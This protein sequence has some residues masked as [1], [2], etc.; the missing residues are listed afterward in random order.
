MAA[1]FDGLPVWS[2]ACPDW[3]RRI[4]AR[5]SLVPCPPLFPAEAE[6]A[7]EVF[8]TL[9][10][11]DAPN[12]P[13]MAEI[14][15]PW[16]LDFVASI[17]G[18]YDAETGRRL[19]QEFF[20][21]ISKKNGKSTTA[22]GIMI[23]AL[24]RNWRESAEFIIL[25]PTIEIAKN[26]FEPARDMVRKHP[27]LADMLL[28]QEHTRTITHRLTNATLKV[29]AADNDTVGGKKGVGVLVDEVWLFGKRAGADAM[30]REALGGLASRPEGFV[31]WLSTQSDEPPRG[32]FRTK[33]QY[34]RGVRDGR[35]DDNRFLPVLYEFPAALLKAEKHKDP[36]HFYITNPN[37]GSSVDVPFLEREHAKALVDGE[38]ALRVFLSKHLNVEIGMALRSDRWAGADYWERPANVDRTLTLDALI[39]RSEVIVL[40]AD[41]GGADDLFGFAALGREKITRRWLLWGHAWAHPDALKRRQANATWYEA[42]REDGDLTVI[43]DYPEDIEG[44]VKLVE[45]VKDAGLFGGIGLDT[46]GIGAL[47]DA[48]AD[49]DVTEENGLVHGVPQ[50]YRLTGTIKTVERKL[51]DGSFVHAGQGLLTWA[52]SNAKVEPTRN[53]VLITKQASGVG[54]I[55]PL[56]AALD[57]AV[58]MECNPKAKRSVYEARGLRRF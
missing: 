36:A 25:A 21:L 23:T 58:L 28:V 3:E 7:L 46:L 9:R 12:S 30:F 18:A 19:I 37:L 10:V 47:V 54:K 24:V 40:G 45:R 38:D 48:L 27:E 41:G 17:F 57:A 1:P 33:L 52:V 29:V 35:I 26:A 22:A 43:A 44:V 13:T 11:V 39:A 8:R 55:D 6:A 50:G 42:F 5:D 16:V 51:I 20:L 4:V 15:R 56:M 31:I 49:I 32:V 34:A 14:C 2:T 53:A